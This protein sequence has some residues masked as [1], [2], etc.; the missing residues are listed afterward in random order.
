MRVYK[1]TQESMVVKEIEVTAFEHDTDKRA[2]WYQR[3]ESGLQSHFAVCP[4]CENPIQILGLYKELANTDLPYG[5]HTGKRIHGF[6][7]FDGEALRWCPYAG[8]KRPGGKAKKGGIDGL[9]RKILQT[10]VDH[11]DRIIHI[12]RD[13]T[14]IRIS[15]NLARQMLE[16]Y[17]AEEGYLYVGATLRNVPWIFAFM[18]D[19]QS[20]F[21]QRIK[22]NDDL[23]KAV[24]TIPGAEV[25]AE[26]NILRRKDGKFFK[27][28]WSFIDHRIAEEGGDLVERV[29][30]HVTDGGHRR[31]HRQDIR[32][33]S[34]RF[35]K[36]LATPPEMAMR[37][38]SLI[39][40]AAD[41]V[42]PH[43][44]R[45]G[46]NVPRPNAATAAAPQSGD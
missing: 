1:I 25:S 43:A 20:I 11:F 39:N 4:A 5:K 26:G 15:N 3:A 42:R 6:P 27:I 38:Q 22:D 13:D 31:V 9:P 17:M 40:L 37:D 44:A 28:M 23:K 33:H 2:P 8:A 10:V 14:G 7:H 29:W 16:T 21:G 46:I 36:L 30:L 32:F 34:F 35:E 41:V 45:L 24:G 19:A 12:L 18:S